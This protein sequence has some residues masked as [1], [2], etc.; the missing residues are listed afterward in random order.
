MT[1]KDLLQRFIFDRLPIRGEFIHLQES[2]Q[3]IINQHPYSQPIRKLL[4]EALCV[5][6]L[7]SAIIKFN[8]RLTVQFRGKGKLKL[9]L[10]QC[11]HNF[12]MRGLV[13]YDSEM[14]YDDL[15]ASFNEG[16]LV[17]MLDSGTNK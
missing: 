1:N 16:V 10:A 7:L 9:L 8:G 6:G 3:T 15:M 11:D 17:I 14:T 13:K 12:Q 4:G 2:Y 5:A